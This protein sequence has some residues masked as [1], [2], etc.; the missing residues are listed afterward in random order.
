MTTLCEWR[1]GVWRLRPQKEP[2]HS[3][4]VRQPAAVRLTASLRLLGPPVTDATVPSSESSSTFATILTLQVG[5]CRVI[6]E[7]SYS[8]RVV[9]AVVA[10]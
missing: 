2:L 8:F 3:L 5:S 9:V 1:M 6:A 4:P 7:F 10:L